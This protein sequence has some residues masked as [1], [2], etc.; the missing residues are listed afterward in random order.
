LSPGA[1]RAALLGWYDLHGRDLPWRREPGAWRVWVSEIMCQQT[2][3]ASALPY[4]ARFMDRF[5]TPAAL[6]AAEV[7]EVLALWAGLG[8]YS[9]AR[10]LHA[11]A[12]RVVAEHGGAVPDDPAAFA[13]LPGVGRYTCGAVQSIA[14]GRALP[15]VDG[16]VIRVLSRLDRVEGDPRSSAAQRVFWARAA[17]LVVGPRPGDLNQ[18]LMELGALVCTPRSPDCPRCPVRSAC[19]AHAA[20]VQESLPPKAKRAPRTRVDRVA[21]LVTDAAGRVWLGRRRADVGLL[22]GL[23]DLPTVDGLSPAALSALGLRAGALLATI[24]HG[25]THR[26]WGVQVFRAQGEPVGTAGLYDEF[27]AVDGPGL[28][29]LALCGPALKGLRACGVAAPARRGAGKVCP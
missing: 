20:G 7:D 28:V 29:A 16:N 8:Y 19:K 22:A 1:L 17:A 26:V 6:A 27:R 4:F 13:A 24:E 12:R 3:I 18:G 9:R 25:F 23:W 5:P 11:A 14:F 15:V 21:G 10:N 2:R